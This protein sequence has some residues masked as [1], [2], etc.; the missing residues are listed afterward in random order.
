VKVRQVVSVVPLSF[1][2]IAVMPLGHPAIVLK[3]SE[4]SALAESLQS[5]VGGAPACHVITR[6]EVEVR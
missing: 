6:N 2:E 3:R 5:V 1:D 4:A